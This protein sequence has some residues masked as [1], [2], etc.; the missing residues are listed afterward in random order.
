MLER[1]GLAG[2]LS[3]KHAAA[4]AG[5]GMMGF[6]DLL[7]TPQFGPRQRLSALVTD[8]PL[9]EDPLLKEDFCAQCVEKK[10]VTACPVDAIK[11]TKGID[12]LK[13]L[14]RYQKYGGRALV[15]F[16][17]KLVE[18]PDAEERTKLLK[19]P[20]VL[21]FYELHQFIRVGGVA[22]VE[23]MRSCPVGT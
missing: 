21:Q 10:C 14:D 12:K 16:L 1:H 2:D 17:R 3:L 9:E 15:R 13:C 5:I 8:A 22:C 7:I 6:S 18:T 4:M 20:S 11:G 23:C 19:F